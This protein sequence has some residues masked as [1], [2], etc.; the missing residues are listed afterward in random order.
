[1]M[2]CL[3]IGGNMRDIDMEYLSEIYVK[4]DVKG[5]LVRI[6]L[7]EV[8]YI[9]AA[10]NYIIIHLE[11]GKCITYLTMGEISGILNPKNFFRIHK[12]F[13]INLSK[14]RSIENG[15]VVLRNNESV[16]IGVK[17]RQDFLTSLGD[18]ILVSL[19]HCKKTNSEY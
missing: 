1:M 2:A 10:L 19:R 14:I 17:Y 13:I 12:S 8:T 5:K 9:E 15:A 6:V 7:T 18:R 4:S 11:G 3:C 16:F